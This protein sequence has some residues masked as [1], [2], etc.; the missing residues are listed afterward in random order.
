[1]FQHNTTSSSA[2]AERPRDALC[3]SVVSLNSA[4]PRTQS[5]IVTSASDIQHA[6]L[7][8]LLCP[9]LL[10]VGDSV[11]LFF[12]SSLSFF[13]ILYGAPAMSLT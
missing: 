13:L 10:T 8:S 3:L 11:V 6:V 5:S 12:F 2:V 4:I 1:M 9:R 7:C